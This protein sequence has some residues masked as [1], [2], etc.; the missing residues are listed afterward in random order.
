MRSANRASEQPDP[1][2]AN[3]RATVIGICARRSGIAQ[4]D[5]AGVDIRGSRSAKI[6]PHHQT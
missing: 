6:S 1:R 4:R 5:V 2:G 3:H